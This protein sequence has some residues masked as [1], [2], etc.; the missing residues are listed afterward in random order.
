MLCCATDRVGIV[1]LESQKVQISRLET[2]NLRLHETLVTVCRGTVGDCRCALIQ[3]PTL[4][5]SAELWD[6]LERLRAVDEAAGKGDGGELSLTLC[7]YSYTTKA[8]TSEEVAVMNRNSE[9]T[10][11]SRCSLEGRCWGG[12]A[13][14]LRWQFVTAPLP[15]SEEGRRCIS[16]GRPIS[17]HRSQSSQQQK[18]EFT[19]L[20]G[21]SRSC[22]SLAKKVCLTIGSS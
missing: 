19:S 8:R 6:L 2:E 12:S 22:R 13:S 5:K 3:T 7:R 1:S 20:F 17:L 21:S 15:F 18:R 4:Q 14:P 16:R 10:G 9:F 11:R